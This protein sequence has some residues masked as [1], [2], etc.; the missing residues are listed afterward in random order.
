MIKNKTAGYFTGH[1]KAAL[2]ENA[3]INK[4]LTENKAN[5][6]GVRRP[7]ERERKS[8]TCNNC[9]RYGH[10]IDKCTN[11]KQCKKYGSK[12]QIAS[13]YKIDRKELTTTCGYCRATGYTSKECITTKQE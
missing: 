12:E 10:T 1:A 2:L 3:V 8:L 4:W 6:G 5:L 9:Y 7:I 11:R 13:E